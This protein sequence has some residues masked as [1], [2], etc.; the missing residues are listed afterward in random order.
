L[1]EDDYI[2]DGLVY[3]PSDPKI[4]KLGHVT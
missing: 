4:S 3:F 1:I 2:Y